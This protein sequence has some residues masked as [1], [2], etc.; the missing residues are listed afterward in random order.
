VTIPVAGRIGA[1]F[2][3]EAKNKSIHSGQ[4][5]SVS[6]Q[7][8]GGNKPAEIITEFHIQATPK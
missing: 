8:P 3:V 5:T 6:V 1:L 2:F 7:V 4:I